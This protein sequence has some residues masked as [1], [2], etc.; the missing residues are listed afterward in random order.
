MARVVGRQGCFA[1][2]G[3][4]EDLAPFLTEVD[5]I[6][7][8]PCEPPDFWRLS[9]PTA[10]FVEILQSPAEIAELSGPELVPNF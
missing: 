10:S 6:G 2:Q 7:G 3:R 9:L 5:P 8:A 1:G 4:D